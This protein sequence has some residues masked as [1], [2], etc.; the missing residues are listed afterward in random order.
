ML[1]FWQ[2]FGKILRMRLEVHQNMNLEAFFVLGGCSVWRSLMGMGDNNNLGNCRKEVNLQQTQTKCFIREKK[3]ALWTVVT[4]I[5][6]ISE[7]N[8]QI[9][10]MRL[11]TKCIFRYLYLFVLRHARKDV[12]IAKKLLIN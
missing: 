10:F 2:H 5:F 12:N 1:P 3:V 7:F 8:S 6:A 11:S 4:C 9:I